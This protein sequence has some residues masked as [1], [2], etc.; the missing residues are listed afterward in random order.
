MLGLWNSWDADA[1]PVDRDSGAY[2]DAS[3][4]RYLNHD[5]EHFQ[6]RGPLNVARSPQHLPV[7]VQAGG[8][9]PGRELAARVADMVYSVQGSLE[10]GQA[11]Y[12]DLKG[13]MP[14]YSRRPDQLK[15][16]PGLLAVVAP[17]RAEA[18]DKY[19]ALQDRVDIELGLAFLQGLLGPDLDVTA[20]PLDEPL[21]QDAV[22]NFGTTQLALL[23]E[24]TE[25]DGLTLR[26]LTRFAT[27]ARGHLFM[28]GS[29]QDVA[30]GMQARFESGA[31]D[32]FNLMPATVPGGMEDFVE[33]V[34]PELQRRGLLRTAYAGSTL[35]HHLGLELH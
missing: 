27:G 22:T 14:R 4:M 9:L 17:T 8:S 10:S 6:V 3:K 13:R 12:A 34:T 31:A 18:E 21:P 29:P 25:K 16:M 35:R 15:I 30:D 28:C 19:A 5:G 1:F 23:K 32:G 33:L 7:M 11:F 26:Q 2:L 24:A 20:L